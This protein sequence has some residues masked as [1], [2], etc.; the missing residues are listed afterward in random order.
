MTSHYEHCRHV[1]VIWVLL[2]PTLNAKITNSYRF[3]IN[4]KI[5]RRCVRRCCVTW[6]MPSLNHHVNMAWSL[7]QGSHQI[8]SLATNTAHARRNHTK[9]PTT[10]K[11]HQITHNTQESHQITHSTHKSHQITHNTQESHQIIHSTH[12]SHQITH[13]PQESH[14]ITPVREFAPQVRE[15]APQV[16]EFAPKCGNSPPKCG[17]LGHNS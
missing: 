6:R 10:H 13:N 3:F 5:H 16:R 11:S 8:T 15:F 1:L 4:P 2:G 14:K 12:K 17:N 9:S 7:P